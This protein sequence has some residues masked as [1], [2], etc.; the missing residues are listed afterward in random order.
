MNHYSKIYK[1]AYETFELSFEDRVCMPSDY[2]ILGGSI[3]CYYFY[4]DIIS[5]EKEVFMKPN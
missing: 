2:Y 5:S 3:I 1:V 4:L